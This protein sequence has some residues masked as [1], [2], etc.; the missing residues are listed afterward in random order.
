MQS[1]DVLVLAKD[2]IFP[3][4]PRP[5][6][7][8][9]DVPKSPEWVAFRRVAGPDEDKVVKGSILSHEQKLT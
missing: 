7:R 5:K 8:H 9:K 4:P 3:Q 2:S 6:G 1:K